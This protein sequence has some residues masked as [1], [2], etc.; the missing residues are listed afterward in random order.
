MTISDAR[1]DFRALSASTELL[2]LANI[3]DAGSARLA[4]VGGA[5]AV[6]TTSAGLAWSNGYADGAQLPVEVHAQALQRI[7]RAVRCPLSADVENGYAEDP[8]VAASHVM[9]LTTD[10]IEGI[11]IED[12]GD[13]PDLLCRKIEAIKQRAAQQGIDL[14]VNARTDVYLR[15]LSAAP[16]AETLRRAEMYREAGADGLFVP[17]L[18]EAGEIAQIVCDQPLP[19]NLM[20]L[21]GL[22]AIDRL[23][24]LGVRRLSAGSAIAQR[25]CGQFASLLAAFQAGGGSA[26]LFEGAAEY[27]ALQAAFAPRASDR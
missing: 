19:L 11:N 1:N 4:E 6:A 15:G 8:G 3:W 9:R 13:A 23:R 22:P 5:P 16:V 25:L 24:S 18:A 12:G 2:L 7:R 17:G 20:N 26:D 10:G 27:G 21:P 14:F